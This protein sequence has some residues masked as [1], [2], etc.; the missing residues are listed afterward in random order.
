MSTSALILFKDSAN[1]CYGVSVQFDGGIEY[2]VGKQLFEFWNNETD[3]KKLCINSKKCIRSFGNSFNEIEYY[4]DS[5]SIIFSKRL[6]NLNLDEALNKSGNFDY[7]YL[8]KEGEI[9]WTVYHPH[10]GESLLNKYFS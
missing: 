2:G 1:I 7:T 6:K 4:D 3:I 10:Y 5:A 8:W 9:G